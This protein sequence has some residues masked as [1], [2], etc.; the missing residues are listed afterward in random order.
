M[1][2]ACE[3]WKSHCASFQS[4]YL[5]ENIKLSVEEIFQFSK[6]CVGEKKI[7]ILQVCVSHI[8]FVMPARKGLLAPQN[9]FLDTIAT[10]FDGTRKW[11]KFDS[12]FLFHLFEEKKPKSWLIKKMI[13]LWLC[14]CWHSC[15]FWIH[16]FHNERSESMSSIL[17]FH[18]LWHQLETKKKR[19][20]E[21]NGCDLK[22]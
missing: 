17:I 10:R 6:S 2:V 18:L 14:T 11:H 16:M 22:S 1:Q 12:L 20:V 3:T 5:I 9:T 8:S 19:R 4:W 15:H 13:E 7:S 21:W